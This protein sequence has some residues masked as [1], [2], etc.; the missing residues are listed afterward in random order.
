[1]IVE[2]DAEKIKQ[3]GEKALSFRGDFAETNRQ[4]NHFMKLFGKNR[5]RNFW[6][7]HDKNIKELEG[8]AY[9]AFR[10]NRYKEDYEYFLD[11]LKNNEMTLKRRNG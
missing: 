1:M 3:N 2:I 6:R 9:K 11:Y 8:E 5:T 4:I 7:E 10:I